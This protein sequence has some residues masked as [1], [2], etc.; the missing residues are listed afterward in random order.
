MALAPVLG[1]QV[2]GAKELREPGCNGESAALSRESNQAG[3]RTRTCISPDSFPKSR[4]FDFLRNNL[5]AKHNISRPC[6]PIAP[7]LP[8]R[9]SLI[10]LNVYHELTFSKQGCSSLT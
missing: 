6:G 1:T 2:S 7:S 3:M 9:R 5:V 10:P 8:H 4:N